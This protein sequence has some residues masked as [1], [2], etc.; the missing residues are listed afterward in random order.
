MK[1]FLTI[2]IAIVFFLGGFYF[3]GYLVDS[4]MF[5]NDSENTEVGVS[6]DIKNL[7]E[8]APEPFVEG[9]ESTLI[10]DLP[11][12]SIV[13]ESNKDKVVIFLRSV[14]SKFPEIFAGAKIYSFKEGFD[15]FSLRS[16]KDSKF[17]NSE[18]RNFLE[19]SGLKSKQKYSSDVYFYIYESSSISCNLYFATDFSESKVKAGGYNL[20]CFSL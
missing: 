12:E 8:K 10:A 3:L 19:K 1:I 17:D 18:F 13:T 14:Q 16:T 7:E 15:K 5:I 20:T 11:Q 9:V 6:N 2:F 4:G